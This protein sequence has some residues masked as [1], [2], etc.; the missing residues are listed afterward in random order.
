[1]RVE[2]AYQQWSTT[3]YFDKD[4]REELLAI[5]DDPE[6][7]RDRFYRELSFGTAGMRGVMGAGTNRMNI[8][9]IRRVSRALALLLE[10]K[11]LGAKRAGVVIGYDSRHGSQLFAEEAAAVFAGHG[12][13]VY[14]HPSIC[15]VPV[16]SFSV[17]HLR[18]AAGVMITAS[19]NP[20]EYNG[21]K[22]YGRDGAQLSPEDCQEVTDLLARMPDYTRLPK[23]DFDFLLKRGGI[24]ILDD[25]VRQTYEQEIKK[26]LV[27]PEHLAENAPR[28]KLV[29]TPLHGAGAKWIPPL[30]RS[31]G[32]EQLS[33]VPE[34]MEPDGDFPTVPVP[35]PEDKGAYSL[36]LKLAR[37]KQADLI[38]ATDPDADRTGVYCRT[39][40]GD[41]VMLN[42]N[43]IGVL[44]LERIL[45]GRKEAGSL[46]EH[47]FVVSTV[48]S[49]RMTE[50]ICKAH[51]ISYTDVLT[52][53]KFIGEQIMQREEKGRETF[54]FGFEESY[55]YLAGSYA[56]DKDAVAACM[57]LAETAA[58]Y[59]AND[60]SLLD[61][62]ETLYRQYGYFEESQVSVAFPGESG[63]AK[64]NEVMETLR[65]RK[66]AVLPGQI[67]FFKDF[68]QSVVLDYK[69]GIQ[70]ELPMPRSN[71]LYYT[72]QNDNWFCV[73]PSGTEPK[74]KLYFG[75]RDGSEEEALQENRL[76]R[77]AVMEQINRLLE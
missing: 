34:Q 39:R 55:G 72:L 47:P 4:T 8:Y 25:R 57:L 21:Y 35:N 38:L 28:L 7:I 19:H 24:R 41:Y 68:D 10:K 18:C 9:V 11:G 26:L 20:K 1:M 51:G 6:A 36:A 73:R 61:A 58:Y 63:M 22:V 56:R 66:G 74:M 27:T 17:R 31:L 64:M 77:E 40:E 12:I 60:L 65:S 32:F 46:P 75:V 43:Q 2:E 52:G 37:E 33:V 14:L 44:L 16:L 71:V 49:T 69:T 59:R 30:L 70:Y 54:L 5:Q 45:S 42:G 62:L 76:L 67:R 53:F 15:P 50:T 29:Y 23:F 48:V 3:I 13:R